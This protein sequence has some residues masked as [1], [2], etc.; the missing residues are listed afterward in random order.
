MNDDKLVQ[1]AVKSLQ[2]LHINFRYES[3][4]DPHPLDTCLWGRVAHIFG[5]GSTRA[6]EMCRRAGVDPEYREEPDGGF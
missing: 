4:D 3:G 1:R 2:N 6:I 5:V